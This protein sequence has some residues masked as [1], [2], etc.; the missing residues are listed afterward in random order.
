MG[1]DFTVDKETGKRHYTVEGM[2]KKND[3]N[4]KNYVN[5][6]FT[7]K[8]KNFPAFQKA[9]EEAGMSFAAWVKN[10]CY[11]FAKKSETQQKKLCIAYTKEI[12]KNRDDNYK[13]NINLPINMTNENYELFQKAAKEAGIGVSAWIKNALTEFAKLP[14]EEQQKCCRAY[15]E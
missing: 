1:E 10:A 5:I 7:V 3:Y 13:K 6:P 2:A 14:I 8:N 9:A 4:K 11:E 12:N 15:S